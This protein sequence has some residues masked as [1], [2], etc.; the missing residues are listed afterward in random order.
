[1]TEEKKDSC[2]GPH[3][4]CCGAKKSFIKILV[5]LLIF[6]LGYLAG[7]SCQPGVCPIPNKSVQV[8]K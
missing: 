2:C 7:K 8:P 3:T 1:M 4:S 5:M 6:G